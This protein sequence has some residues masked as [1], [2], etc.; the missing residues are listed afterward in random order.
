MHRCYPLSVFSHAAVMNDWRLRGQ[1][2]GKHVWIVIVAPIGRLVVSRHVNGRLQVQGVP[3]GTPRFQ[4]AERA[5]HQQMWEARACL[6]GEWHLVKGIS[7]EQAE[8]EFEDQWQAE[9]AGLNILPTPLA[10]D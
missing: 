6:I 3:L 10:Q 5:I 9:K 8:R 2:A 4:Q 1:E 7:W